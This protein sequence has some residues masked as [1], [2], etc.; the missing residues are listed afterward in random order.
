MKLL[1]TCSSRNWG[2]NEKWTAMAAT[3]LSEDHDV[4]YCVRSLKIMKS[5]SSEVRRTRLPFLNELDPV[6]IIGLIFLIRKHRIECIISTKQKEYF[7]CGLVAKWCGIRHVMRLGIVRQLSDSFRDRLLY[8]HFNDA[9]LVNALPI[10]TVLLQS[11]FLRSHPVEVIY[12]G[13]S[14]QEISIHPYSGQ[15]VI[16]SAGSLIRRKRFHCLIE[17]IAR[18]PLSARQRLNLKIIGS[19]PDEA[20]L[21]D[22]IRNTGLEQT[23]FLTGFRE[24]PEALIAKSDLFVLCS[25]NEGISNALL[26]AMAAGVPVLVTPAG[27]NRDVIQTGVNGF[28][29]ENSNPAVL[30]EAIRQII[31]RTDLKQIGAR[32]RAT[33]H[34]RFS[35]AQ[36][37]DELTRF[38]KKVIHEKSD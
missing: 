31:E 18:I 12:N 9:I 32:G 16:T 11:P 4:Y 5:V 2:G 28:L 27:G 30:A 1:F 17:A 35:I 33:V 20:A 26:E 29:V 23:V 36:M 24:H 13:V 15:F 10:K 8:R 34:S 14:C 3:A 37:R 25:E 6:T 22:L 38:L 19:G 7:L 21:R